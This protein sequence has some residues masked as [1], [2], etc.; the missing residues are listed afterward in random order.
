MTP[1]FTDDRL[2]RWMVRTS[3][4]RLGQAAYIAR[5]HTPISEEWWRRVN[6]VLDDVADR[7]VDSPGAMRADTPLERLPVAL[8]RAA[9]PGHRSADGQVRRAPALRADLF[10]DHTRPYL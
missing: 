1:N 8:E 7:L 2:Q 3:D 9:G 4:I 6:A 5:P 10:Y